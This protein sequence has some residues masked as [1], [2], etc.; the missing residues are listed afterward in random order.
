MKELIHK[1]RQIFRSTRIIENKFKYQLLCW[2]CV[3]IHLTFSILMFIGD[4]Y[5]LA[6]LNLAATIFYAVMALVLVP[7]E[8][9]KLLFM[10]AIVEIE[11]NASIA[12]IMLGRDYEFM[13]Y[14]ISLIPGAFYVTNTWPVDER[15]KHRNR[16]IPIIISAYICI[17]Y[18]LVDT[19]YPV[20]TPQ[21][22]GEKISDMRMG[23]HYFN[24]M[25]ALF[26]L[27]AFSILFALEVRYFQ[28]ILND[29]NA[30]LGK[31][32]SID[33][34]T[35]ALNRRSFTEHINDE[36]KN[37]TELG[38]GLILLDIDDFKKINDTYGHIMGDEVLVRVAGVMRENLREGDFLGRWGGEEFLL[39]VHGT[40]E[41]CV[42]VAER[43]RES[44]AGE[45]FDTEKVQFSVTATL[46]LA[47]YQAG[48][49]VRTLVDMADQ[50]M[51]YGKT[52]GKNQ[53][54]K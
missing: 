19:L 14:T 17:S 5:L 45:V 23:F 30:R 11:F 36:I 54:V 46:G 35:K 10:M 15:H 51:Y 22:A 29:E 9:Y 26:V 32:A 25:I 18:I 49:Q 41:D 42:T 31:I 16:L 47:E 27:L 2:G 48:L 13:L 34:L 6:G 3:F 1:L 28:K 37:N 12:S 8:Q 44:I 21:F 4:V 24:I 39:L 43:V 40:S 52:H 20:V 33:P 53:V 38:F 50:K 7:R